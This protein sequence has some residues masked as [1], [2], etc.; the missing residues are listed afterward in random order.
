MPVRAHSGSRLSYS[1]RAIPREL[2]WLVQ[3]IARSVSWL[4][5]SRWVIH[6]K[7]AQLI[8]VMAHAGS[9]QLLAHGGFRL[10]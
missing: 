8:L 9:W 1:M 4:S 6:S 10:S 2:A 7:N 5:Y 3:V